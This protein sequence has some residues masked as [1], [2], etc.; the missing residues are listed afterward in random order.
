MWHPQI[1]SSEYNEL[2]TIHHY[3]S[4]F[5]SDF[6]RWEK[7]AWKPTKKVIDRVDMI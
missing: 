4:N 7:K 3:E 6:V 2:K 5:I 1:S